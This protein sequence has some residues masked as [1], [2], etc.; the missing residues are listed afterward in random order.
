[1]MCRGQFQVAIGPKALWGFDPPSLH[2]L[3][4]RL[5]ISRFDP[6]FAKMHRS[7]GQ[8]VP[9][10]VIGM[11]I[12]GTGGRDGI[13]RSH[14]LGA[15]YA[16]ERIMGPR[17]KPGAQCSQLRPIIFCGVCPSCT[18]LP[19]SGGWPTDGCFPRP[20]LSATMSSA[21]TAPPN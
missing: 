7:I 14:Y 20:F 4:K 8:V 5:Q 16:M 1:M 6:V 2:P 21:F 15:V 12:V 19:L 13:N 18:C 17:C 9:H 11:A 10:E 3:F